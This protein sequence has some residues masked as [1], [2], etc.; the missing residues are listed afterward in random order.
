MP[1][2]AIVQTSSAQAIPQSD[3]TRRYLAKN[4]PRRKRAGLKRNRFRYQRWLY[5]VLSDLGALLNLEHLIENHG[6]SSRLHPA[7]LPITK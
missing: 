5:T 7:R 1:D 6:S 4:C 3:D 2:E